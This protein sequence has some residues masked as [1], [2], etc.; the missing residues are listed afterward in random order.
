MKLFKMTKKLQKQLNSFFENAVSSLKLNE[1]SFVINNE[2]KNI[3]DRTEK[4]IVKYQFHPSI[5][6]NKNKIENTNTFRFKLVMLSDIKNE[7]NGLNPNKATTHNNIPPKI[8]WQ[9]ADVTGNTLQL[10]F[11]NAISNSEFPENLKLTDVT[12]VFKKKGPIGKTN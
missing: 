7:I 12:P 1:N 11:N 3:Q 5:L 10:L 6:I 8:L 2:H 4:I 9:S